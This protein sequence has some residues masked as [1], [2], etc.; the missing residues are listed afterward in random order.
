MM[1]IVKKPMDLGTIRNR[2]DAKDGKGYNNLYE[3]CDDVR[4]VF[5]NAMT[6]NE[7]GTDVHKM[8][9]TLAAKFEEKW[10]LLEA[11]IVE[12]VREFW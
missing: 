9:K 2:M 7:Q 10:K 12:E 3:I 4:L 5:S 1:Q 11:K 8:A 6:Y